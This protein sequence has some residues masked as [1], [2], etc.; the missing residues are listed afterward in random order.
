MVDNTYIQSHNFLQRMTVIDIDE[1]IKKN[2]SN[3]ETVPLILTFATKGDKEAFRGFAK[4]CGVT[5]KH[6]LLRATLSTRV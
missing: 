5:I 3:I 4:D 6:S 1:A 2:K